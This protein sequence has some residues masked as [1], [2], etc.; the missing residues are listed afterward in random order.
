MLHLCIIYS[1]KCEEK[2][3]TQF[4]SWRKLQINQK[5]EEERNNA[6]PTG[7]AVPYILVEVSVNPES[8]E[9]AALGLSKLAKEKKKKTS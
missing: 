1:S 9:F 6:V 7:A 8:T 3:L 2:I 5:K 4:Q